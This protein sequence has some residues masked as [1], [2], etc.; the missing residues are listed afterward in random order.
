MPRERVWRA[1]TDHEGMVAWSPLSKVVVV[2]DGNPERNGLGAVRE[3]RGLGLR[4]VEEVVAWEPPAAFDYT[5]TRGAP[6]R[7]HRGRIELADHGGV[8]R[9]T[10]SVRFR[11]LIPGTGWLLKRVLAAALA[12]MLR[13]LAARVEAEPE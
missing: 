8:C 12:D 5:L 11:P 1:I 13:R 4:I 2:R 6:V 7:E 3:L 9:I 10:W